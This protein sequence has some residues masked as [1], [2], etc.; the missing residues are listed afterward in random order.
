M[1]RAIDAR[2]VTQFGEG[3]ETEFKS[4][5][6][7]WGDYRGREKLHNVRRRLGSESHNHV[8]AATGIDIQGAVNLYR[9][10]IFVGS[11]F[12]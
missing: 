7:G 11:C 10:L 12:P 3:M 6:G 8:S 1:A 2:K 4:D 9:G 5:C